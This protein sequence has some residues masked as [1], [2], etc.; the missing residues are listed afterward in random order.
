MTILVFARLQLLPTCSALL[1]YY[2]SSIIIILFITKK[3]YNYHLLFITFCFVINIYCYSL[4]FCV[5][6]M[7]RY[8]LLFLILLL[9]L[10]VFS[11]ARERERE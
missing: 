3:E 5:F 4:L 1:D 11:L 7:L 10:F 8:Y 9:W 6:L 2:L